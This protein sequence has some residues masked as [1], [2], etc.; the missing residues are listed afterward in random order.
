[1]I[2]KL[3]F[4]ILAINL[5]FSANIS[6]SAFAEDEIETSYAQSAS[7]Y[8]NYR[9][10]IKLYKLPFDKTFYLALSS[11]AGS[12]YELVEIQSRNGYIKFRTDGRDFLISVYKKDK[13]STYVKISPCNNS[14]YFS[15]TIVQKI[16]NY[17]ASHYNNEVKELK[18]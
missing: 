9:D 11:V 8:T 2:K 4:L 1:M 18:F 14:Y 17:I 15:Q 12:K 7:K 3:F 10:C 6:S 16:F 13:N 5:I